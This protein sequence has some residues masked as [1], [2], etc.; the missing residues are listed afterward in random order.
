MLP[1]QPED[2]QTSNL[3]AALQNVQI[4]LRTFAKILLHRASNR[5]G[6]FYKFQ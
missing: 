1:R 4:Q 3:H 6:I 2:K 5:Y